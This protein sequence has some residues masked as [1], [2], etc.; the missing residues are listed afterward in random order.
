MVVHMYT[1]VVYHTLDSQRLL[2][3]RE[4]QKVSKCSDFAQSKGGSFEPLVT[5]SSWSITASAKKLLQVMCSSQD[6]TDPKLSRCTY[7]FWLA[8]I[9]FSL[10]K[11]A[12]TEV[13][14]HSAKVSGRQY[15]GPFAS[16]SFPD[17]VDTH[18][19]MNG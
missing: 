15:S 13:V 4:A 11:T 18:F 5:G 12:A 1:I 17:P 14:E 6:T 3:K 10:H 16:N 19:E 9:S 8:K 7:D 2:K